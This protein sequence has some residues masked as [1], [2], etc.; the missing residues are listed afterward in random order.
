M[1]NMALLYD[2]DCPLCRWYTGIFVK[3]GIL[4]AA[5]RISYNQYVVLHPNEVDTTIAQTKIACLNRQTNH[6]L[7][8]IDGL[9]AILGNRF[10]IIGI[11]G[12][13]K[14]I[15]WLL[16]LLYL[17]FSYNR[18]IVAPAP[19][20][21]IACSCE[22][23]QSVFWRI[24]FIGIMSYLTYAIVHWYFVSFLG[25]YLV[26]HP[27]ND[28][29]LLLAQILFQWLAFAALHQE[30]GYDY[31]GHLVFTSFLGALVL[32]FFGLGIHLLSFTGIQTGF[33]A[34]VCYGATV[35]FMFFEHKRRIALN[36]WTRKLSLTWILFRLCIYP[37]VFQL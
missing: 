26:L 2:E 17:F 28:L 31:L 30:N 12:N 16:K 15:N 25:N 21:N 34:V 18:R 8:G 33:L 27:V 35:A 14:P 11:L 5:G 1:K 32:F 9:V 4:D 7:Y 13:F 10:R 3:Y 19:K 24:I 22:P 23:A 29:L 6:I 36:K 37:L 20:K